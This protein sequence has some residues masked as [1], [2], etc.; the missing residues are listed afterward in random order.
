MTAVALETGPF[1]GTTFLSRFL[2]YRVKTAFLLG[3]SGGVLGQNSTVPEPIPPKFP[4]AIPMS[5]IQKT[6]KGYRVQLQVKGSRDSATFDTKREAQLWAAQREIDL[7]TMAQGR[8]G[9]IRTVQDAFDRYAREV[10]PDHKG[11]RWEV[12]RLTKLGREFDRVMLDKLT[13]AHVVKW[14]DLR[15]L[16]VGPASVLREMKLLSAVFEQCRKE[17]K[18]LIVNPAKDVRKPTAPPHRERVLSLNEIKRLLRALGYPGRTLP[19]HAVAH[20]MLLALRTGMRQGELAGL[21]WADVSPDYVRLHDT[22]NGSSRDVPLSAKARRLL[23]KMR[24][25]S[26]DLV[27]RTKAGNIDVLFRAAK[28]RAGVSGCVWHDTRHTA[29]TWIGSTGRLNL[30]EFCKMF[31]WRDPRHAMI[32]FNPTASDLAAKL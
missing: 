17:W 12:V 21:R 18:W 2:L 31:G 14:R 20:A 19:R 7:Q 11:E 10:S 24:G 1:L 29:A 8:E 28:T 4:H 15:L 5:S 23:E 27:Y 9:S 13:T 22:K 32:Y 16:Q 3:D 25:Y 26:T 30:M 6:A